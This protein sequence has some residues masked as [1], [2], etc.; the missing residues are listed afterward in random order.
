MAKAI[1]ATADLEQSVEARQQEMQEAQRAMEDAYK[2]HK[3]AL[4][5]QVDQS[6]KAR[7][8]R[9]QTPEEL[10]E[11]DNKIQE[12]IGGA[13]ASSPEEIAE[14]LKQAAQKCYEALKIKLLAEAQAA[15]TSSVIFSNEYSKTSNMT[16]SIKI[17]STSIY[18]T[19]STLE[20]NLKRL[21]ASSQVNIFNQ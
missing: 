3:N 16:D 10:K 21:A 18:T 19:L 20:F 6:A 13:S 14:Q 5:S 1:A 2:S 11:L 15:Q 8:Q 17:G 12:L 9:E 4:G 7:E